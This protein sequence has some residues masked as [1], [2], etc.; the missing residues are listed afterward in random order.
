MIIYKVLT[1]CSLKLKIIPLKSLELVAG[2]FLA[3]PN[4]RI[5]VSELQLML[6]L[7]LVKCEGFPVP[8]SS[9]FKS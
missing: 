4:S 2:E 1:I 8:W 9:A 6:L 3:P 5:W 7:D